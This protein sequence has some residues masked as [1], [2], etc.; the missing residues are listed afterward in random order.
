MKTTAVTLVDVRGDIEDFADLIGRSG[1][2]RL[3][4]D[5]VGSFCYGGNDWLEFHRKRVT[6]KGDQIRVHTGMGN[7]FVFDTKE[8]DNHG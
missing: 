5:G 1:K 2:L 3:S 6:R 7:T 4:S 8:N